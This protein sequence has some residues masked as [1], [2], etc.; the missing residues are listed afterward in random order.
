MGDW[1][2]LDHAP[3]DGSFPI[4]CASMVATND[5]P[6]WYAAYTRHNHERTVLDHF[7]QRSLESWFPTYET[8]RRWKDR[9]VQLRFPL[10]PGYIFVRVALKE[11][12]RILDVPGFVRLV[13]FGGSPTPLT[14]EDISAVQK[15][16]HCACRRVEPCAYLFAGARVR[17]I[18]GPFQGMEGAVVRRKGNLRVVVSLE[19]IKS[20][21]MVEVDQ[22]EI[23]PAFPA[24]QPLLRGGC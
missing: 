5:E 8:T 19:L 13:G 6:H 22:A 10:F 1:I 24:R 15:A 17:I 12:R 4:D 3:V 20:S 16:C 18:D 23:R 2:T 14:N 11:R 9:K 7:V 21:F